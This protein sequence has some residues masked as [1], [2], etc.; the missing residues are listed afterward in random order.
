MSV[1]RELNWDKDNR[2]NGRKDDGVVPSLTPWVGTR[3]HPL[4]LLLLTFTLLSLFLKLLLKLGRNHR[5]AT[6]LGCVTK[7]LN[8]IRIQDLL[9][10][11]LLPLSLVLEIGSLFGDHLEPCVLL[12][13]LI[14]LLLFVELD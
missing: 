8:S 7:D 12:G 2:D 14:D 10:L 6:L 13:L 9:E 5:I 3:Y 1:E 4:I 11:S